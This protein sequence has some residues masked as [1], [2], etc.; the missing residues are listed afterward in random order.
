M[1]T[2]NSR[3]GR[4]TGKSENSENSRSGEESGISSKKADSCKK[5]TRRKLG[6]PFG[7]KPLARP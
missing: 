4:E 3:S 1:Q 6:S 2:E 7:R 5:S